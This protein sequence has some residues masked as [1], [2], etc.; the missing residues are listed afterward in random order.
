MMKMSFTCGNPLIQLV[1]LQ[2]DVQKHAVQTYLEVGAL[3]CQVSVMEGDGCQSHSTPTCLPGQSSS[4]RL[5]IP[6]VWRAGVLACAYKQVGWRSIESDVEGG[7][8]TNKER[9]THP[10]SFDHWVIQAFHSC[11]NMETRE[12]THDFRAVTHFQVLY[13]LRFFG[14]FPLSMACR[15]RIRPP[16]PGDSAPRTHSAP[17]KP[18]ATQRAPQGGRT[19]RW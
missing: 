12:F 15:A 9:S 6:H 8:P 16:T 14:W 19:P 18:R 5:R 17:R 7:V 4:G 13:F 2:Y 10:L 3:C 11:S 1:E